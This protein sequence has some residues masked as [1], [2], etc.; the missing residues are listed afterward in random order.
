MKAPVAGTLFLILAGLLLTAAPAQA[1]IILVDD[2]EVQ[3]PS[4]LFNTIQAAINAANPSDIVRVCPG[5]YNEQIVIDNT[6]ASPLTVRGDSGAIIRPS[7]MSANTTS[8]TSGAPMAAVVLIKDATALT[9]IQTI[10]VDAGGNGSAGCSPHIVGILVQNADAKVLNAA[11]RNAELGAGLEGCQ[12]GLGIFAQ[13][14]GDTSNVT[15]EGTSV[16][17]YQKNGIT[18][19]EPGTTLTAKTNRVT[20]WGPTDEIAQNGIQIGFGA[21]GLIDSNTIANHVWTPCVSTEDCAFTSSNILVYDPDSVAPPTKVLRNHVIN[22]QVNIYIE[23]NGSTVSTNN[24]TDTDVWD[25]IFVLGN[26][27]T[28][29]SNS[30]FNSDEAGVFVYSATSNIVTKNKINEA[31]V[32]VWNYPGGPGNTVAP[33]TYYNVVH[34][35]VSGPGPLSASSIEDRVSAVR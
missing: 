32:G 19:N 16:H 11:V 25:G 7:P 6:K 24:V 4:A 15:V 21:S 20:G 27:N 13:S 22:S 3:C 17:D 1:V 8:L 9:N 10:T 34:K 28:V 30:I 26:S 2:D 23:A 33:N 5:V 31:L 35:N 12:T 29:Q 14:S 18:A